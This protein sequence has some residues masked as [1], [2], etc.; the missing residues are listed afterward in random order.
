MIASCTLSQFNMFSSPPISAND[1]SF[2]FLL[3][4]CNTFHKQQTKAKPKPTATATAASLHVLLRASVVL[5][6]YE[7]TFVF[8]MGLGR[9]AIMF[10]SFLLTGS[11]SK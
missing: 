1:N 5:E 2:L 4:E 10:F 3:I 8:C 11:N 7:T 6:V 9:I